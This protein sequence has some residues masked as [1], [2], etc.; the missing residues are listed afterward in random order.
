MRTLD[1]YIIREISIPII[2]ALYILVFLFII[3]DVFDN[4]Y[5]IINNEIPFYDIFLY[6]ANLIPFAVVQTISWAT[7]LGTLYLFATFA[8]NNEIIA[9]K[10][11]G[12]N[13][14]KIASPI[15][16]LGLI[17]GVLTFVIND[18]IVPH[19]FQKAESLRKEKFEIKA[20]KTRPSIIHNSTLL[21]DNRQYY[22]KEFDTK[23]NTMHDIRIHVLSADNRVKQKIIAQDAQYKNNQWVFETVSIYYLDRKGRIVGDPEIYEQK[24][25]EE[26]TEKPSDFIAASFDEAFLSSKELEH[27]IE[28][29]KDNG[30]NVKTELASFHHKRALPWQSLVI[31]FITIPVLGRSGNSRRGLCKKSI[32]MCLLLVLAYH[33]L[34]SI[35]LALGKSGFLLPVISAWIANIICISI[36]ITLFEKSNY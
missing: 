30:L 5:E 21:S 23:N 34:A 18:R 36:S 13:M 22:V 27:H 7:F 8:H 14:T 31:M 10:A 24:F 16:F 29:L 15:L 6:Y 2:F 33:I 17:I 25:F 4:L 32:L 3:A 19:T 9:M 12:L 35:G 20:E 28:R 1:R 11:A 26:F